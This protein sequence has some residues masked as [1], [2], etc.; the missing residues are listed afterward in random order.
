[1]FSFAELPAR[2]LVPSRIALLAVLGLSLLGTTGCYK[3]NAC[4]GPEECNYLDDDCDLRRDEDFRD[5]QGRYVDVE[6]CGGCAIDCAALIPSAAEVACELDE[7]GVPGCVRVACAPGEVPSPDG[8]CVP[9][10]ALLC[11]P[12]ALDAECLAVADG[13]RCVTPEGDADPACMPPCD[14]DGACPE[15]FGCEGFV[16]MPSRGRAFCECLPE[17]VGE[18]FACTVVS[19][20]GDRCAGTRTC[21]EDGYGA[22]EAILEERCNHADDD[23]D[24]LTDEGIAAGE[25]VYVDPLHCG[26]CDT[27]CVP[28]GAN[29]VAECVPD[30][31]RPGGARCEQTCEE[32]FVDVDG[33]LGN[34]CECERFD[35]EGPPPAAGGDADCDGVPDDS[36]E[37]IYVAPDGNDLA[38]GTLITPMRTIQAAL[39]RGAAAGKDVLVASGVYEGP[40]ALV[41]GV[42]LYGGYR[43]DFRD[44]DPALHP[45]RIEAADAGQPALMCTGIRGPLEVEGFE[46][47]G[48]DAVLEGGGSTT[49]YLD[50]CGPGVVLRDLIVTA[51]RGAP[52][53]RGLGSSE[54]LA[55]L[56]FDSLA[57]LDG[58]DGAGGT[59]GTTASNSCSVIPAGGGGAKQCGA[60]AVSGGD[61]GDG[62]CPD[63]GCVNGAACGNG[64]CTD[65]T[66][67][68]VCDFETVLAVAVPNPAAAPGSGVSPGDAGERT[69]NAPT[70]RGTCNFCDDNPTLARIG[71]RGGDGGR[72]ADGR[73]GEGCGLAPLFDQTTGILRG[74]AGEPGVN[75][76]NGSGGGGGSAGGGYAVIGGTRGTCGDR[77]GGSG[78]G[79]GSGG[80]GA[81]RATGGGG[82][83]AS[84]G[85]AIRLG[86]APNGPTLERVQVFTASGGSGGDGGV[87]APGG[88]GGVGAAG[89][90]ARFWCARNG[91][92]GGDG[93]AGGAGGGGGGGCGGGAHAIFIARGAHDAAPYA[94]RLEAGVEVASTGAAGAGGRGGFSPGEPG[95]DG[96]GGGA[97]SI[98]IEE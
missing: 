28:Q 91:G 31:T 25:G 85:I 66:V 57:D 71:E 93:G 96:Q 92:R 1:M 19:P 13:A 42:S 89:G 49:V 37:F 87:G 43:A 20:A 73:G 54:N 55:E 84:V 22:C 48:N 3:K 35:G 70:N 36:D 50:G 72:G 4:E 59:D 23:C 11:L 88:R 74:R 52:G 27:P 61:G 80:C 46:V 83:G 67:G 9:Q 76:S 6:H 63:L 81:P 5:E 38:A 58:I 95:G 82:G 32:G 18:P 39:A 14:A 2:R 41:E 15:G 34:G 97:A 51:G 68:G 24:G 64:G 56:G 90:V 62:D 30:G 94:E 65:F 10:S 77:A 44:R 78:G 98:A 69:Y 40:V 60:Q 75:G 47:L 86:T 17:L 7:A 21:E 79:G 29:L 45:V 12:C 16:C 33:L 8:G 26:A 53:L